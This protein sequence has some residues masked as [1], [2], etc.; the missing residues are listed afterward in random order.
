MEGK[1]LATE[2]PADYV[3]AYL[4]VECGEFLKGERT[5]RKDAF[6]ELLRLLRDMIARRNDGTVY[7]F[8]FH[9]KLF[10][11]RIMGRLEYLCQNVPQ[12]EYKVY[13]GYERNDK[14]GAYCPQ[15]AVIRKS[16]DEMDDVNMYPVLTT[17]VSDDESKIDVLISSAR[18]TIR[19]GNKRKD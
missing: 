14:N 10:E 12:D 8:P 17:M 6:A 3:S 13:A 18:Q 16:D 11:Q 1:F 9:I 4:V 5:E 19:L 7:S 2:C 15:I